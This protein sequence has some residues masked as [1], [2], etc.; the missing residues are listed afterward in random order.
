MPLPLPSLHPLLLLTA[1]LVLPAPAMAQARQDEARS[2]CETLGKRLR[3]V[4]PQECRKLGL[5]PGPIRSVQGRPLM[6]RDVP[7]RPVQLSSLKGGGTVR[8][9]RIFVIGGIHGDELTSV[10]VVFRW[11][12]W[13]GETRASR[14]HWRIAPLS[15]PDGLLA[16]PSRRTNG[17]GVDLNR[18]FPTPDWFTKAIPYWTQRTGKDPRRYPGKEPMSEPETRWLHGEIEQFRPDVIVSIH[19][20]YGILDYDGPA[21]EP[22]R[23]G[24][25]NLNRLG[26]YPGSLGNFG[27][28]HKNIPVITI[29][30]PH[31]TAMPSLHDQRQIWDDMLDWIARHIVPQTLS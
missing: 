23:F 26:V 22:R 3:S 15:N 29:E 13:L 10:S 19:A 20:P 16:R 1:L 31:A 4:D 17:N 24:R 2:W 18:N 9:V 12:E 30:L 27:G 7:P 21:Q 14:H 6:I 11:M 8:P 5:A 25:L 28:V